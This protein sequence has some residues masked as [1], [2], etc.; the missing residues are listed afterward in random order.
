MALSRHLR[1]MVR[2]SVA[3]L[4][5]LTVPRRPGVVILAYHRVGGETSQ[6]LDLPTDAFEYQ[7]RYLK[8]YH[9]VVS[10]DHLIEKE[11]GHSWAEDVSVVSFD[12]GYEDVYV[13]AFPV[14]RKY[15][16]PAV[17]YLSTEFIETGRPFPW[18]PDEARPL[19]WTQVREMTDSGLVVVGSHTHTHPNLGRLRPEEIEWELSTSKHM[20]QDRLGLEEVHFSYP[21]PSRVAGN[22]CPPATDALVRSK[23]I[24][25]AVIGQSKNVPPLEIHRLTRVSVQQSDTPALF[26]SGLSG[27]LGPY[28]RLSGLV[29]ALRSVRR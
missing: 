26:R 14:L 23:F 28:D 10:L 2:S 9:R 24:S 17:M 11:G 29:H 19:S 3:L 7:M 27:Y 16:I 22:F 15:G 13:N 4:G 12:D 8:E 18:T 1:R 21:M 5:R 25:A 6:E 20:M